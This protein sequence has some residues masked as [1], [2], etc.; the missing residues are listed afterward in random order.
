[1]FFTVLH[2]RS[3][4]VANDVHKK[5][6]FQK[7]ASDL[8]CHASEFDVLYLHTSRA[9]GLSRGQDVAVRMTRSHLVRFFVL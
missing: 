3:Y 4:G 8:R 5:H 2:A 1:V 9:G 6:R 7:H